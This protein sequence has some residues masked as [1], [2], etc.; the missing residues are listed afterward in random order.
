MGPLFTDLRLPILAACALGAGPWVF[1]RGFRHLHTVR[2]IENTPTAHIRAMAMGLVELHGRAHAR[3]VQ[4]APF[5]GRE[6]AY[7]EVDVSVRGRGRNSWTVVHRNRSGHPFFLED[8][9]GIALVYP[10]GA[11]C[12]LRFGTEEEC[13]GLTPPS[14]YAEYLSEHPTVMTSMARLSMMRFRERAL[15]DGQEVYVIGTA[16]PRGQARVVSEGEAL[17]TGT[18][19]DPW[20]A[21]L[22]ALD[23]EACAIVRRGENESTF[24]IAQEQERDLA[25]GLRLKAAAMILGGPPIALF[26]LGYWLLAL[27]SSHMPG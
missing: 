4:A 2:L 21:R 23:H 24:I 18:D 3:S 27:A 8:D 16:T 20:T 13:F 9:T 1:W 11:D 10:Q 26:G 7:W 5:S 22:R 17:A 12:R 25:T 15:E 14:P 6:C 19:G